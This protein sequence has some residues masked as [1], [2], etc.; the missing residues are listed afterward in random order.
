LALAQAAVEE[1]LNGHLSTFDE[2]DECFLETLERNA[3]TASSGDSGDDDDAEGCANDVSVE[4]TTRRQLETSQ[5]GRVLISRIGSG[6]LRSLSLPDLA[7][8]MDDDGGDDAINARANYSSSD[9]ARIKDE[10]AMRV[11]S[12]SAT[13][14]PQFV[15]QRAAP[16]RPSGGIFMSRR[17]QPH[18]AKHGGSARPTRTPPSPPAAAAIAPTLSSFEDGASL[19]KASWMPI[20]MSAGN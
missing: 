4:Q 8:S 11:G 20:M 9:F 7:V 6:A 19:R 12:A 2:S 5:H 10:E 15:V 1:F 17:R 14:F 13:S 16:A 18:V 3:Q